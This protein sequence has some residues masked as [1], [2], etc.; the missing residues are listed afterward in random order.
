[1][2]SRALRPATCAAPGQ[3][4]VRSRPSRPGHEQC[5]SPEPL[6]GTQ[7]HAPNGK[8]AREAGLGW[9]GHKVPRTCNPCQTATIASRQPASPAAASLHRS[10][11]FLAAP[12]AIFLPA[13]R[14]RSERLCKATLRE[15]AGKLCAGHSC[16]VAGPGEERCSSSS[17]PRRA[18]LGGNEL[19]PV[20]RLLPAAQ[21]KLSCC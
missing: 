12:R 15:G 2:P 16:P 3:G 1:M 9:A 6:A 17:L 7:L 14:A 11:S 10:P 18:A 19:P 20:C 8:D 5:Q 13:L 4:L 21:M